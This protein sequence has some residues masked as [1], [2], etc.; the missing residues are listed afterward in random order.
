VAETACDFYP[1]EALLRGFSKGLGLNH[2]PYTRLR[3]LAR[4]KHSSFVINR[5]NLFY[6]D[7]V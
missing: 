2:K 5:R 4:N 1:S 7:Y 3:R 6:I